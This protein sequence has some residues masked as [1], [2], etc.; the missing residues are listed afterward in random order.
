MW[1]D[2]TNYMWELSFNMRSLH[3]YQTCVYMCVC[4]LGCT[5]LEKIRQMKISGYSQLSF[6]HWRPTR[7]MCLQIF[8]FL[9]QVEGDSQFICRFMLCPTFVFH[10]FIFLPERVPL[11]MHSEKGRN[12]RELED[13]KRNSRVA[14]H[15][16]WP[17][18]IGR[19][20]DE[21]KRHNWITEANLRGKNEREWN[22]WGKRNA[23][24]LKRQNRWRAHQR[25]T[26]RWIGL[27]FHSFYRKWNS[28]II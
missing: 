25:Q 18:R 26:D 8:Y 27:F 15:I 16:L 22:L 11:L 9:S 14:L 17:T 2:A 10:L 20:N 5:C 23:D 7:E 12:V 6:F 13:D 24:W 28:C 3:S 4:E 19:E 1:L 21:G